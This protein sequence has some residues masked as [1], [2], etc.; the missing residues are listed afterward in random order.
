MRKCRP[1][2]QH[3]ISG[4][5]ILLYGLVVVLPLSTHAYCDTLA[6]KCQRLRDQYSQT[7][8]LHVK[9]NI[10]L[11]YYPPNG[12]SGTKDVSGNYEYWSKNNN[13]RVNYAV[14]TENTF[15]ED[16]SIAYDGDKFQRLD[17]LQSR[18]T[19]QNENRKMMP[20]LP[21]NPA[22]VPVLFLQLANHFD[23]GDKMQISDLE[24]ENI[25]KNTL[26]KARSLDVSDTSQNTMAIEIPV[27]SDNGNYTVRTF[28]GSDPSYMPTKIEKSIPG[29]GTAVFELQKYKQLVIDG[30][31]TFWPE[32]IKIEIRGNDGKVIHKIEYMI[33]TFEINNPVQASVFNIDLS[34]AEVV[35]D[36]NVQVFVRNKGDLILPPEIDDPYSQES[37]KHPVPEENNITDNVTFGQNAETIDSKTQEVMS[38]SAFPKSLDNKT[39]QMSNWKIFLTLCSLIMACLV[40]AL[41]FRKLKRRGNS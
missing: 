14:G 24:N 1:S 19:Y 29:K 36:E 18:L 9:A 21:P 32:Q 40:M 41:I 11:T 38:D 6:E 12:Q 20:S 23:R 35:Y 30:K 7:S 13:Y 26:A 28:F 39:G 15:T 2:I 22:M 31:E 33:D 16:L 17:R 8:S 5:T 10:K 27:D 34:E 3:A 4:Q 37:E 25:W